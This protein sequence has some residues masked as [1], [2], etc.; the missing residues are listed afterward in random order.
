MKA[1]VQMCW[2]KCNVVVEECKADVQR[3]ILIEEEK[4]KG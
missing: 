4:F 2:L 3:K 1:L